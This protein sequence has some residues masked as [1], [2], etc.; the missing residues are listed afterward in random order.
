MFGSRCTCTKLILTFFSLKH[1]RPHTAFLTTCYLFIK[2]SK[3]LYLRPHCTMLDC[4]LSSKKTAQSWNN[5]L[6]RSCEKLIA[7]SMVFRYYREGNQQLRRCC[8]SGFDFFIAFI[9]RSRRCNR[10]A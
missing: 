10:D 8:L 7:G 6:S 1:T 4:Y 5:Q 2:I 3:N 9:D